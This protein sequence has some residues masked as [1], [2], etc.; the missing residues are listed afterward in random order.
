MILKNQKFKILNNLSKNK[1]LATIKFKCHKFYRVFIT[2]CQIPITILSSFCDKKNIFFIKKFNENT[3][4]LYDC[5][6]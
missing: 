5:K 3:F 1:F 6:K 4:S 2:F